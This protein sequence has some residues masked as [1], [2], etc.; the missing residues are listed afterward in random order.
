LSTGDTSVPVPAQPARHGEGSQVLERIHPLR[1]ALVHVGLA[2]TFAIGT[3][4]LAATSSAPS[5]DAS[6]TVAA[7]RITESQY[8]HIAADLF[9]PEI[10][11]NARF[12]PERRE[13]GLLAIGSAQLSLTSAGFEQ[14]F[15]L[16]TTISEQVL[17]EQ[18]RMTAVPC[19]PA[20]AAKADDAC[21]REFIESYGER[22]FRRP[23]TNAELLPRMKTAAL[24]ST[25]SR[26]FY[27]GLKLALTS[28][29]VAPE[30]LF[31][32]E[33]AE[34]DPADPQQYRLDGY[35]KAARVSFLFWDSAPDAELRAAARSGAIHTEEGLRA[36][37]RRLVASERYEDGARAFFAD[38]LQLDGFENLVKD[39]AIYPK[40]NQ[41][42]SDSAR[43]ETLRYT[44]D[45]LVR[46][47]HDYRELFT[48]NETFINRTLASV[49]KVPYASAQSWMPYAFPESSERSG[50]L[51]QA[52]FLSLFSHPGAS[53]PTRRGIK[54]YEIFMCEP[55]PNP[56][57]NTDFSK[58]Q[59]SS[60]GT[61]RGRLLDHMENEACS[62]CHRRSD[63][64]GLALEHFDGLGQLR[65]MENGA[66]IDV[67]AELKG[68]KFEGA[69]GLG[70]YLHDDPRV[71]ACLVR[72]VYA[73]GVGRKTYGRDAP[74]LAQQ[75]QAFASNGY[76][77]PDLMVQIA[78]SPEFFKVVIPPGTAPASATMP[79][80]TARSQTTGGV[81]Q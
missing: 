43:E 4:A 67:R 19:R 47:K 57:A 59:D 39:P 6:R 60:K 41:A 17:A 29:L 25:Q 35:T 10:R 74:Y 51:T 21:A 44:L 62:G 58:V 46:R 42:V 34:P 66:P 13:D 7:R 78:S 61:V 79:P 9:G 80:K 65:T 54:V 26:D 2:A 53:S 73:Y 37:L 32:V 8:R 52:S 3:A 36:Q 33:T 31:R 1:H 64:P 69:T 15:A 24:G 30:F 11:I 55:T 40:F 14:Y 56:P 22:L 5:A 68:V 76:R 23:L 12:E 72:N 63:P 28:L 50:I 49:Y 48:S 71:P 38:M 70:R 81:V 20:D 77:V 16:A 18:R 75:T 45:L 27:A